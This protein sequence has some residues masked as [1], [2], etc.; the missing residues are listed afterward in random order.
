MQAKGGGEPPKNVE[1]PATNG[2]QRQI[3][4]SYLD[5]A[6]LELVR[7][8]AIDN[9]DLGKEVGVLPGQDLHHLQLRLI[10]QPGRRWLGQDK[11]TLPQCVGGERLLV[12]PFRQKW[13]RGARSRTRWG[14]PASDTIPVCHGGGNTRV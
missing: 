10:G 9:D 12:V 11:A 3:I 13:R 2:E 7:I 4:I 6:A 14:A 1:W 5:V 8:P